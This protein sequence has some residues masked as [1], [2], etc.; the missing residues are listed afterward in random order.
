MFVIVSNNQCYK[1]KFRITTE[2]ENVLLPKS[3]FYVA[4]N[5][6][7]TKQMF[8]IAQKIDP[9]KPWGKFRV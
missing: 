1:A 9:A 2:D 7:L 6:G 8:F 3:E 5:D 4:T